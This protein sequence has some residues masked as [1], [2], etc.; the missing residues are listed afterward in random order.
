M[1]SEQRIA[2]GDEAP[3]WETVTYNYSFNL[4][5]IETGSD[6]YLTRYGLTSAG[7]DTSWRVQQWGIAKSQVGQHHAALNA[8]QKLFKY[9]TVNPNISVNHDWVPE[10]KK[11]TQQPDCTVT[12]SPARGFFTRTTFSTGV[13]VGTKFYGVLDSRGILGMS[14]VRHV[15]TPSIGLTYTPNF[16]DNEFGYVKRIYNPVDKIWHIYDPWV[17]TAAGATPGNRSQSLSI[18]VSNLFQAKVDTGS[19]EGSNKIDLFSWNLG[20]SCNFA[21][22]SLRWSNLGMSWHANPYSGGNGLISSVSVDLSTSHSFYKFHYTNE[23]LKIGNEVNQYYWNR[24]SSFPSF[25]RFKTA[26]TSFSFGWQKPLKKIEQLKTSDSTKTDP[27]AGRLS[28]PQDTRQAGYDPFTGQYRRDPYSGQPLVYTPQSKWSG[29]TS[30]SGSY[31]VSNPKLERKAVTMNN[32]IALSLTP[33]WSLNYTLGVDLITRQV[34]SSEIS[35]HKD[36]HCWQISFRWNPTGFNPGFY[37]LINVKNPD[38][39]DLKLERKNNSY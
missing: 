16:K 28:L 38:L 26:S 17:G 23:A 33:T 1:T 14:S 18:S 12:S 34:N 32:S 21:A 22:D 6:P 4:R 3:W 35:T 24:S 19:G 5:A 7:Y 9:F 36:L 39:Q 8:P 10:V 13:S 27:D 11:Y 31:D 29:N 2:L 37:L 30:F 20:T 25:L 15:V